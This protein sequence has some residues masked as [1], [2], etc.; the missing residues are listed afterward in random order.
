M[1]NNGYSWRNVRHGSSYSLPKSEHFGRWVSVAIV[2]AIILHVL[3]F[4]GLKNMTIVMDSIGEILEIKTEQVRVVEVDSMDTIPEA[5]PEK[6]ETPEVTGELLEE[7]EALEALPENMEIDMSPAIQE[8]EFNVKMEVPA[9]KGSDLADSLE[10]IAGPKFDEQLTDLGKMDDII[11]PAAAG[12]IIIDPG[13]MSADVYDPDKFNEQMEKKGANGLADKGSLD[14]FTP[15]G[16]MANLSGN[17]LENATGMIGSD[18]L[19]DYNKATLRESARN[20]L[21][22]VAL[23]I[24]KNPELNCWIG[25]HT[26]LIG[27]DDF[28]YE[29]SVRRA[30]AVKD[31]LVNSMRIE[32]ERLIVIGYG[33]NE[34]LVMEGDENAQALNRRVEIKMRRG[35]PES[36]DTQVVKKPQP[37]KP[38]VEEQ[39]EE[40][41]PPKAILVKPK[42]PP[43]IKEPEVTPGK[44]IPAE[45]QPSRAV[46]VD[47]EPG[48]AVIEPE[49][50]RAVPVE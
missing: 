21:L 13:E 42:G 31:W 10:P 9:L 19:F 36:S 7:I 46:P 18:L 6:V 29:L 20:S 17:A 5:K 38:V 30:Q 14:K 22:K 34:P 40:A 11:Q 37:P 25:G 41:T 32:P 24:D 8:P 35:T 44:A 4:F 33:E 23:L 48:R 45:P 2:L 50:S 47:P 27:G 49:T 3:L 15:L 28:N 1:A 16:E 39:P 12:Q 43:I 26:D